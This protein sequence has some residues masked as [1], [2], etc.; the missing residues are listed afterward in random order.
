MGHDGRTKHI[1]LK[2]LLINEPVFIFLKRIPC[3]MEK[4]AEGVLVQRKGKGGADP[5]MGWDCGSA[6]YDA[7]E[8][9]SLANIIERHMVSLPSSSRSFSSSVEFLEE[10]DGR[11][12]HTASL[13]SSSR[14][15]TSSVVELQEEEDERRKRVKEDSCRRRRKKKKVRGITSRLYRFCTR[16]GL[17]KK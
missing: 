7:Y 15:F 5:S 8:L 6:L 14:S 2:L 3:A 16:I 10:E 11:K 17:M 4:K 1:V 12:R 9:I 13:P